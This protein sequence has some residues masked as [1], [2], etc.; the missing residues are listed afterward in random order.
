[1]KNA[2]TA[3]PCVERG[4]ESPFLEGS[5]WS[6]HLLKVALVFF[7]KNKITYGE[8]F[9]GGGGEGSKIMDLV[10]LSLFCIVMIF[11]WHR[12]CIR[13]VGRQWMYD[14]CSNTACLLFWVSWELV[15]RQ[16]PS[17][18]QN[19]IAICKSSGLM[20]KTVCLLHFR[21]KIIFCTIFSNEVVV[22]KSKKMWNEDLILKV[23]KCI[24]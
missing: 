9:H 13:F 12:A 3:A 22:Y 2:S 10:K 14:Q 11:V 1:M 24:W 6:Y 18:G 8:N 21:E 7:P 16:T 17:S 20:T 19:N 15:T 23:L 5:L 4:K